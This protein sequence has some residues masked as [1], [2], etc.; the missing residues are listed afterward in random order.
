M[1]F[2]IVLAFTLVLAVCGILKVIFAATRLRQRPLLDAKLLASIRKQKFAGGLYFWLSAS[3]LV[4][5]ISGYAT[6]VEIL[7]ALALGLAIV[8]A[9]MIIGATLHS[10]REGVPKNSRSSADE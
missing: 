4:L 8:Y 3:A 5:L 6:P 1:L 2:K 7:V 9:A 10:G